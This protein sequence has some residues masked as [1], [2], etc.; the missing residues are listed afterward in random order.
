MNNKYRKIFL[1]YFLFIFIVIQTVC[2]KEQTVNAV[3][4]VQTVF[5]DVTVESGNKTVI[6]VP[7]TVIMENSIVKTGSLSIIDIKYKD[8]GVIRINEN[9]NMKISQLFSSSQG[10]DT[11]LMMNKGTVFISISKLK[12]DSR[13][14][15]KTPTA[16]AGIRGTSFKVSADD[17]K[18]RIDV[19][20]GKILVNPVKDNQVIKSV[21]QFVETNNT[22][23][24]E[25]KDIDNI[26]AKKEVIEVVKLKPEEVQV[27]KDEAKLIKVDETLNEEIKKEIK[28]IGI[29]T[30]SEEQGKDNKKYEEDLKLQLEKQ[31]ADREVIE[32][33]PEK[34][35]EKNKDDKSLK[36]NA[37]LEKLE[38]EKIRKEKLAK[39]AMVK[40]KEKEENRVKN[41][42]NF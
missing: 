40:E 31:K 1:L 7:G 9:S 34:L 14:E 26:V 2:K 22:A 32:K 21:E 8:S 23:E 10:E 24:V 20:S 35:A 33:T 5:G 4:T 42:P 13:F 38:Q 37:R 30:K 12:K 17:E 3:L 19:L 16:V 27:I 11:V 25:K 39:E 29:E 18:S 6:P 28:D 36:E 41:I 15:V